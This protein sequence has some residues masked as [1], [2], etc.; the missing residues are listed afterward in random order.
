[1]EQ[2]NLPTA[3]DDV[4][5]LNVC[6]LVMLTNYSSHILQGGEVCAAL[7]IKPGPQMKP[8]MARVVEWQLS[9]PGESKAACE[10]FLKEEQA[11]GRLVT[12]AA[13]LFNGSDG[14]RKADQ[15]G[16]TSKKPKKQTS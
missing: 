6:A 5:L 4:P 2:L 10:S 14:K 16:K 7:S 9:H 8:I 11:M 12:S 1:M 13:S 3:I 15:E